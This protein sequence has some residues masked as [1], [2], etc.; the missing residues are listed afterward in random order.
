MTL[1]SKSFNIY[2][3]LPI[4]EASTVT[5]ECNKCDDLPA[6]TTPNLDFSGILDNCIDNNLTFLDVGREDSCPVGNKHSDGNKRAL[7]S[8]QLDRPQ[9]MTLRS[10]DF[11][12]SLP[13]ACG[14]GPAPCVTGKSKATHPK[15]SCKPH[16]AMKYVSNVF[17]PMIAAILDDCIEDHKSALDVDVDV[18]VNVDVDVD[19]DGDG[20]GG[21][22]VEMNAHCNGD[23]SSN[24]NKEKVALMDTLFDQAGKIESGSIKALTR[25]RVHASSATRPGETKR[26]ATRLTNK[27]KA[28]DCENKS[29]HQSNVL[30]RRSARLAA[31][32]LATLATLATLSKEDEKCL[33]PDH[34]PPQLQPQLRLQVQVHEDRHS[35]TLLTTKRVPSKHSCCQRQ[36]ASNQICPCPPLLGSVVLNGQRRSLRLRG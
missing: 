15:S 17:N 2:C 11:P 13:I 26:K 28:I 36:A 3:D 6:L 31:R 30:L 18:D 25:H 10:A 4:K 23:N 27:K 9:W 32:S 34:D 1:T 21:C 29:L 20:D 35:H 8:E 7:S 19:I 5:W 33:V 12:Q 22:D 24:D 14:P 16:V